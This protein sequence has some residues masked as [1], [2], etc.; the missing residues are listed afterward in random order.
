MKCSICKKDA[1]RMIAV[2]FDDAN[3]DGF[4]LQMC[5]TEWE[6]RCKAHK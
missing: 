3:T 1:T 5:V 2:R 6:F 4:K